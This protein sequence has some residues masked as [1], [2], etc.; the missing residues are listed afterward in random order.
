MSGN[1]QQNIT[2]GLEFF[3]GHLGFGI[4]CKDKLENYQSCLIA[5]CQN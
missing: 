5:D 4:D 2:F 3:Y 1:V